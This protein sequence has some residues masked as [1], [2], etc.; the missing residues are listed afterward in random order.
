[1]SK[2]KI[3]VINS[4]DKQIGTNGDFTVVFPTQDASNAVIRIT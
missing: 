3:L 4:K 1:M 2:E